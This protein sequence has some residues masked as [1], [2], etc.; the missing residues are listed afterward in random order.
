MKYIVHHGTG[1]IISADECVIVNVTDE[2]ADAMSGD[3]YFDDQLVLDLAHETGQAIQANDLKYGNTMAF[4]PSALREEAECILDAG[5]Y[6]ED[7]SWHEAMKWCIE[8]AT[9]DHLDAVASYILDDD[10]LWTTYR[11]SVTE[12]LLQ[13]LIWHKEITKGKS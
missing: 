12:G 3:D 9:D 1:T 5:I 13:G 7:E 4:S 11:R 10:D 6:S 8:T 2:M